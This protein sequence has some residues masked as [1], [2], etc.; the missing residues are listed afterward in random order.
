M[1][2]KNNRLGSGGNSRGLFRHD[3]NPFEQGLNLRLHLLDLR[4]LARDLV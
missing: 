1:V 4:V 3:G 2:S